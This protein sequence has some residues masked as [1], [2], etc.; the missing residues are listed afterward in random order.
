MKLLPKNVTPIYSTGFSSGIIIDIGVLS[1][2]IIPINEGFPYIDKIEEIDLSYM[3]LEREFK[4]MIIEDN[5][6]NPV[7]PKIGKVKNID[8]F[9]ESLN[10]G[11]DDLLTRSMFC[12][13]RKTSELLKNPVEFSKLK[14]EINKIDHNFGSFYSNM[15]RRVM[16]GTKFFGDYNLEEVNFAYSLLKLIKNLPCEDRKKLSS[17][18]I[19]NGGLT[20]TFGFYKR[21]V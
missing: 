16:I 1:S 5:I 12:A 2:N 10:P 18:I 9:S 21:M 20:M 8:F 4:L 3:D 15:A 7:N 11:L 14:N 19:L 13:N 6:T 17:N